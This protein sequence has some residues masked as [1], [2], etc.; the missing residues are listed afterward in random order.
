MTKYI[1]KCGRVVAKST[2]ADNTGNRDTENCKG[3][4]YL[5]PWGPTEWT[6]KGFEQNV[7]GHECRMS[8]EISYATDYSGGADDKRTMAIHSLDLDFLEEVQAWIDEYADGQLS[9]RFSRDTIRRTDYCNKG[10]YSWS[11]SCAQ[12][13]KG[14]AAKAALIERFFGPDKHRLDKTPEEEKAIVLAAIEAGKAK[15][16][17]RKEN[18]DYIISKH[19]ATGRLYA[20]YKG[21]F[22]FWDSHIQRWLLSQFAEDLYQEERPKR[23]NFEREHFLAQTSD[24][25]QLDD[26]EVPSRCIETLLQ[27]NP[28]TAIPAP[29][30]AESPEIVDECSKPNCTCS[31]CKRQDC[32]CAGGCDASGRG[33]CD[34]EKNCAQDGCTYTAKHRENPTDAAPASLADAGAATQN[35]SGAEPASLEAPPSGSLAFD[36]SGLDKKTAATLHAAERL[37]FEARRDY[38]TGLANAVHIAHEALCGGVVQNLDNSK[39]GN[40]GDDA[41]ASWCASVGL[42]RSTAYNLLQVNALLSGATAEE[43]ATLEAAS[44]SLLYAAAKPSA[45]AELVQ[46]VKDG[47]ITTHKQFKELE[48]KLKAEREARVKAQ[49]DLETVERARDAEHEANS[50]LL[51]DEQ[52]RRQAAD[53]A[54]I[55]AEKKVQQYLQQYREIKDAAL[56]T[57]KQQREKTEAAERRA[58]AAE[59]EVKSWEADGQKMQ[60]IVDDQQAVIEEQKARIGE[61]ESG[62]TVEAAA[63]DQAEIERRANELSEPLVKIINQQNEQIERMASGNTVSAQ[64]SVLEQYLE[65]MKTSLLGNARRAELAC[66]DVGAL[67]SLAQ[68]LREFAD[69]IDGLFEEGEENEE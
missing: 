51:A 35:L 7:Q 9:G 61:L 16:Q 37:I 1:C 40:R 33:K 59:A 10:R 2:S 32:T 27:C 67:D 4:P 41:F 55:A 36:Y 45:P 31:D 58:Q 39:H 5:L 28:K 60:E 12:N 50:A 18:M 44:P 56:E 48:A 24:F 25:H 21:S 53:E 57:V 8:P 49:Q 52:R 63:V 54:R 19:E 62:I 15:A 3:C 29:A 46:A 47:D 68:A 64:A 42:K 43:Q 66:Y 23:W 38:V 22:W 30:S 20:Y 65:T 17:E 26:Y 34:G 11:I 14:M 13:K 6:G 69:E